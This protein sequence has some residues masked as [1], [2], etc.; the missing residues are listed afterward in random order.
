[1]SLDIQAAGAIFVV[2]FVSSYI[3]YI[4]AWIGGAFAVIMALGSGG[5][6]DG[7]IMLGA[8]LVVNLGLQSAVQPFA[9][10]ATMKVSPLGVF[11]FTLLGGMVA[12]VFGAMMAA[13]DHGPDHALQHRRTAAG[14]RRRGRACRRDGPAGTT[15]LRVGC[16]R[17]DPGR[18]VSCEIARATALRVS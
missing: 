10:G 3:P 6:A 15:R 12:G 2:L 4:G 13:P 16:C 17:A 18:R 9:F 8:V 14:R 11:L 1:M 5:T 7:W